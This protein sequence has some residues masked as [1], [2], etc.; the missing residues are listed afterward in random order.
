MRICL[1]RAHFSTRRR[2]RKLIFVL[3]LP[4]KEYQR[5][6]FCLKDETYSVA[7]LKLQELRKAFIL[8]DPIEILRYAASKDCRLPDPYTSAM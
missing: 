6:P 8:V 4:F 3:Q 1:S 7:L 2:V 5:W